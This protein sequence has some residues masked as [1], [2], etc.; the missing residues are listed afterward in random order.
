MNTQTPSKKKIDAWLVHTHIKN[1]EIHHQGL[2][3]LA[4]H[5]VFLNEFE[6]RLR[7]EEPSVTIPYWNAFKDP[8]PEEL[9]K[10]SDN[11]GERVRFDGRRLA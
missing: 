5:R 1:G 7:R 3:F 10:I 9:K 11:E 6:K 4:W 2:L 8:F